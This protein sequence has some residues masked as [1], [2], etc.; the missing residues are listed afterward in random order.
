MIS[1]L[2]FH[3]IFYDLDDAVFCSGDPV[4]SF[5]RVAPG[6][7]ESPPM[8]PLSEFALAGKR[9]GPFAELFRRFQKI[10]VLATPAQYA[11]Q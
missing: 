2:S 8:W 3:L 7:P 11:L 5:T 1:V 6:P 10:V 4:Q 9:I